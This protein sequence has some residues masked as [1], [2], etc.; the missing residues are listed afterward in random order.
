LWLLS[1]VFHE[2]KQPQVLEENVT[3]DTSASTDD[4][5]R[6]SRTR[7]L[8]PPGGVFSR[9]PLEHPKPRVLGSQTAVVTGPPGEEIHCD[10]YGRVRVQFHWDREGQ[11]DDKSSCWLRV[12]SG[13]AGNGYG[14]IVIPR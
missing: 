6:G 1:E 8:A 4:F 7:S 3:S 5:Q 9:P 11:G 12:A 10:Q 2:G 14:G 13:W